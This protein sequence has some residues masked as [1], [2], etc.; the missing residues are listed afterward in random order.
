MDSFF[1]VCIG[2]LNY[3]YSP[4]A[5]A[6]AAIVNL[7]AGK[8]IMLHPISEKEM[9]DLISDPRSKSAQTLHGNRELF[10]AFVQRNAA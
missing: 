5:D 9:M 8:N 10:N 3:L 2:V 4:N 7:I 6:T 1:L